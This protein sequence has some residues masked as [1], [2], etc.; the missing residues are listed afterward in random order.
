MKVDVIRTDDKRIVPNYL[1]EITKDFLDFTFIIVRTDGTKTN[2][3]FVCT[4]TSTCTY[5]IKTNLIITIN[6]VPDWQISW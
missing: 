2:F 6:E 5:M 3:G 4:Q 1:V